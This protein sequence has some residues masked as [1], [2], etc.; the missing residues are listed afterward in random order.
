M[1]FSSQRFPL[2]RLQERPPPEG[3]DPLWL[4]RYLEDDEFQVSGPLPR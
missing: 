2:S 1:Q 4:E 3:C